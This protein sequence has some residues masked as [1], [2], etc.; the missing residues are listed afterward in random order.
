MNTSDHRFS[1]SPRAIKGKPDQHLSGA[2]LCAMLA[3][4]ALA[5]WNAYAGDDGMTTASQQNAYVLRV[6][7]LACPYCAYGIEKQFSALQG[8]TDTRIDLV[9][10]VVIVQVKPTVRLSESQIRKTIDDAG[11][12]LKRIVHSPQARP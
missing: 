8:V 9:Q 3:L 12:T 2:L 7:G 10:G 6:D 11:F 5:P 1:Y 4:A